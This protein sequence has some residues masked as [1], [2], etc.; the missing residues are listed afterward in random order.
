MSCAP[1]VAARPPA[2][3]AAW[4]SPP[5]VSTAALYI[6]EPAWMARARALDGYTAA[7][8]IP[9][10]LSAGLR[11]GACVP[12]ISCSSLLHT[13]TVAC[14]ASNMPVMWALGRCAEGQSEFCEPVSATP[15]KKPTTA[16]AGDAES[17]PVPG[18]KKKKLRKNTRRIQLHRVRLQHYFESDPLVEWQCETLVSAIEAAAAAA[19][20]EEG[21]SLSAGGPWGGTGSPGGT[22]RAPRAL[23][24]A[25]S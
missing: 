1:A 2:A 19:R 4:W 25:E 14:F 5:C 7:G 6:H 17:R 18:Q 24:I 9:S 15:M 22:V 11:R 16:P 13:V 20:A 8:T 12:P 3:H 23:Q 21:G 10:V